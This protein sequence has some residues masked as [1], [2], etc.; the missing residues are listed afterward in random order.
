MFSELL[1]Y[2]RGLFLSDVINVL[3]RH[4]FESTSSRFDWGYYRKVMEK[5]GSYNQSQNGGNGYNAG[6]PYYGEHTYSGSYIYYGYFNNLFS[7]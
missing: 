6:A 1:E 2:L 7:K 4:C 5:V 3:T